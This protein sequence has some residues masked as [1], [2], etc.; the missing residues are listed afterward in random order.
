MLKHVIEIA[1]WENAVPP[2]GGI[3]AGEMP[4]SHNTW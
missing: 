2:P 1:E 4:T 3:P